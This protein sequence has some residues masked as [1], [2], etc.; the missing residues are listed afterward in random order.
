MSPLIDLQRRMVEV[1]RIRAGDKTPAGHPRKLA[2]WRLTSPDKTR[3]EHAGA[4][5]G[6]KLT[7]WEG[8]WQLHTETAEL[9]I[10]LLP[11]HPPTS[12]YELWSKGGCQRRCDGQHEQISDS[13]CLCGADRECSPTTRLSVLLPD[14]QGLGSW[15][16]SSTGW[17]AAAE[18]AGSAELLQRAS[19]Q[20]VLIPARLR[21]EQRT[22]VK[23]GQTRKFA[24]PVIDID[25]SFR[26]LLGGE[27]GSSPL[28]EL[29]AGYTPVE[30]RADNGTTLAQGLEI[31]HTQTH[32][33]RAKGQTPRPQLDDDI[34]FGAGPVVA[35][36]ETPQAPT[37]AEADAIQKAVNEPEDGEPPKGAK[38]TTATVAQRTKLNVLVG[39]LR[40]AH[41]TTE[42]L[43][44]SLGRTRDL[45][46]EMIAEL[47]GGRDL[48]GV[49]HWA[50]LRDSLTRAEATDLI[51]RLEIKEAARA[52]AEEAARAA[53]EATDA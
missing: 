12:W 41:I 3:L 28:P 10:M 33:S 35:E 6:G 24:V 27:T 17:N 1:G 50:P 40:P 31:A 38:P 7:E 37:P 21:L 8:Q 43:Y 29:P 47:V 25:V 18:L 26:Q 13:A 16:L 20:G 30:P 51:D 44:A 23:A 39:K 49:L 46:A 2:N 32:I 45:P 53:E 15:L 9:P 36:P 4:L 22:S 14:I 34:E 11:G 19:A 5:W 42:Q 52:A 48:E